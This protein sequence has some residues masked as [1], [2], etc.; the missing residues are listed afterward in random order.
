MH[1]IEILRNPESVV[2]RPVYAVAG[3]EAYLRAEALAAIERAVLGDADPAWAVARFA[4]ETAGLAD[5]LDE[6]RMV[7]LLAKRRVVLVEDAD[8][9]VSAH[10]KELEGYVDRPSANNVLVLA[11]K[12]WPSNTR[13]AKAVEAKGLTIECK[14]PPER[15]LPA[16]LTGFAKAREGVKLDDAAARLLLELVGPDVGRL[17]SELAKLVNYVGDRRAIRRDDVATMVGAG[18]VETIWRILD[19]AT[20]GDPAGALADLDRLLASGEHPVGLLAAM[21]ASLRKLHH[22]G[23][24]RLAK[25]DA[26]DA[27]RAAGIPPFAVETALRQHTHLG[28]A[29]VAG[30]PN[31]LLRADLDLKGGSQLPPRVVL[32]RLVVDLARPRRD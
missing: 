21:T 22:A 11:V 16:W 6:L 2:V 17:A 29:R 24:L 7:P 20:T 4:G 19:A 25:R 9:F 12:T 27:C 28:P 14:S 5:V 26:R 8:K 32:E 23:M 13:L 15:E 3:D 30:L 1:A 31:R 10:R 18:R